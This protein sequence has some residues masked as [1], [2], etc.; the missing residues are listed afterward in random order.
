MGSRW[1]GW[2]AWLVLRGVVLMWWVWQWWAMVVRVVGSP[3]M[4]VLVGELRA[5]MVAPG[6][7]W[8]MVVVVVSLVWRASMVRG[9][10]MFCMSL[11]R[12]VMR[13]AASVRLRTPAVW[14]AVSSPMLWPRR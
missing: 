8:R 1:G 7:L 10:V 4:T 9:V 6:W 14:A 5:A 12:V 2:K 11:A 3:V 13:V